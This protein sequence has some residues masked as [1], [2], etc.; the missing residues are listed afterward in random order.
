MSAIW[1]QKNCVRKA[2]RIKVMSKKLN[3]FKKI[4]RRKSPFMC[5][6]VLCVMNYVLCVMEYFLCFK[7][8]N[9]KK[10]MKTKNGSISGVFWWKINIAIQKTFLVAWSN[11][12]FW[13]MLH[14]DIIKTCPINLHVKSC[15]TWLKKNTLFSG[16]RVLVSSNLLLKN[17]NS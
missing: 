11:W 4:S 13:W 12:I 7:T 14:F 5:Y 2:F 17:F 1:W 6:K 3:T 15:Q 9:P 8:V 16:T 10:T